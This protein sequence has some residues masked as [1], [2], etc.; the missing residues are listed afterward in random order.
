MNDAIRTIKRPL[1]AYLE[2]IIKFCSGIIIIVQIL[3]CAL[4]VIS[5]EFI[6]HLLD[7]T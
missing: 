4:V 2:C 6:M 1:F 3:D 5:N 7:Y